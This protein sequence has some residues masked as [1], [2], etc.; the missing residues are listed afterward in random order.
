VPRKRLSRRLNTNVLVVA[1]VLTAVDAVTKAWARSQLVAHSIHVGGPF[2][3]RLQYNSGISF[4]LSQSKSTITSVVTALIVLGVLAASLLA[5][6]GISTAGFGLLLGGGVGNIVDR[7]MA[8]P[9]EV[10]DFISVGSFPIF[11][12]ADASITVGFIVL[13]I[14]TIRGEKLLN[15]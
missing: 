3:F 4:S 12:V 11:N 2:W 5:R 1:L 6:P 10:T 15:R 13:L 9:H 8:T 14:A 7:L